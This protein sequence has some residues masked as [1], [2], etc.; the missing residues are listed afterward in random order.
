M[1]Q[2]LCSQ[3]KETELNAFI[4]RCGWFI[5]WSGHIIRGNTSCCIVLISATSHLFQ[6]WHTRTSLILAIS[7]C[8]CLL[9]CAVVLF[10]SVRFVF[11]TFFSSFQTCHLI[12][13]NVQRRES[14]RSPHYWWRFIIP[15]AERVCCVCVC[16]PL[17]SGFKKMLNQH[18]SVYTF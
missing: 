14:T 3:K 18:L 2:T 9:G 13:L 8:L 5:C 16:A 15:D 1:D 4:M 7:T 17:F 6:L 11:L 10:H 12:P